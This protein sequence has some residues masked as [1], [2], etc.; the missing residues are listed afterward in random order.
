MFKICVVGCGY[1]SKGGHGPAFKKYH[2]EYQDVCLA[3]CCDIDEEKAVKYKEKFGF[4]KHY[5]DYKAMLNEINPDVVSLICP[6]NFTK[7]LSIDIMK[8]GYNIILEKPPGLNTAEI[9]EMI[10]TAE[11]SNVFVR[12][13]FNRRYAPLILK[14]KEL[15]SEQQIFNITYQM[16]RYNRR[17]EDFATTAIHAID[18]TKNIVGSDYKKID[19]VYQQL[20]DIGENVANIYLNCE[21]ENGIIGQIS[22]V[23]MGGGIAERI[24][25]NTLD[26][27]YYVELPFWRNMDSPGR[28]RVVNKNETILDIS[29][30]ELVDSPEMFEEMGFY[31]ENRGF[32][33]LIRS[34]G[35]VSCDLKTGLQSVDIANYIRERK[36]QY[37]KEN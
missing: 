32:F 17:D 22:L 15:I 12:T 20:S 3:G 35:P 16:Y 11:E 30:T 4:E 2:N 19:F 29:G 31:E 5:T 14:L 1:M 13:S 24:T 37:N 9:N 36:P 26:N 6:V 7:E 18:A 33:E 34:G 8:K 27:T 25:V 10:S 28:L 23:P 21:F